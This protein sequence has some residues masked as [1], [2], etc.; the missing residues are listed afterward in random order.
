MQ[1]LLSMLVLSYTVLEASREIWK[2]HVISLY[3][4]LT[5]EKIR[6]YMTGA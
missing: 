5:V 6:A 1:D 2:R 3:P 4:N